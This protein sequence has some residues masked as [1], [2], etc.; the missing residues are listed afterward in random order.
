MEKH[1]RDL[2]RPTEVLKSSALP[3]ANINIPLLLKDGCVWE[4]VERNSNSR[5]ARIHQLQVDEEN[6]TMYSR[7]KF[8]GTKSRIEKIV[9]FL[10]E[11]QGE[12]AS[13]LFVLGQEHDI[14][15][16]QQDGSKLCELQQSY[17]DVGR[18]LLQLL[19]SLEM[20]AIGVR[21]ILKKFDKRC[22]YKFTNYYVKT[23]ANH[24]YSQLRQIF[25]HA[26]VGTYL[27]NLAD[28][29]DNKGNYT[30]IYDHPGLPFQDPI[31]GSIHQ[32]VDRL[33]NSTDFLHYLGKHALILPEELPTPSED[34]AA[35]EG[36]HD[37][38][39]A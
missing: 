30:S 19:F 32:A 37:V 14:L 9:L 6:E 38:T 35:D 15:V 18:E 39:S 25:K 17:R 34:H 13:R 29:Q 11:Q 5:M 36:Y 24:P 1:K 21:K 31:I 10:L 22:G 23:R 4:K 12:L 7:L 28:L 2:Q 3:A 26:V 8:L 20:N 33:T 27:L 16:Q